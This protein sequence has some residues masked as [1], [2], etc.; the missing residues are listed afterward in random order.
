MIRV[1]STYYVDIINQCIKLISLYHRYLQLLCNFFPNM[2]LQICFGDFIK[3]LEAN[4]NNSTYTFLK[5]N[6]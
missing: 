2:I 3:A 1:I 4:N 6:S 5:R